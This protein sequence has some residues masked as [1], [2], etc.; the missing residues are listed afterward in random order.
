MHLPCAVGSRDVLASISC[1]EKDFKQVMRKEPALRAATSSL[2]T[3]ASPAPHPV[4]CASTRTNRIAQVAHGPWWEPCYFLS[5][6]F[7]RLLQDGVSVFLASSQRPCCLREVTERA[8]PAPAPMLG[9]GSY[10]QGG[11]AVRETRAGHGESLVFP[12]TVDML[13]AHCEAR[14]SI[15]LIWKL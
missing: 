2:L 5:C 1:K 6:W 14:P 8:P 10:Q 12:G 4:S 13:W 9:H 15:S 11:F 7:A 3:C